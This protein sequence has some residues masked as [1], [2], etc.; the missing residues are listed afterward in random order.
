V[1]VTASDAVSGLGTTFYQL[2]GAA[3][4]TCTG[5]VN[6]SAEGANTL[7]YWSVDAAGNAEAM[8]T[9][10]VRI[11][12]TFPSTA[13]NADTAWHKATFP[14]T[15]TASDTP[16]GLAASYYTV[17][18]GA[19]TTYTGPVSISA[20]GTNTVVFWSVDRAGN[21][22]SRGSAQVLIDLTAPVTSS[23]ATSSYTSTATIHLTASD[24]LSGVASTSWRADGGAWSSEP[25]AVVSTPG[26]HVIEYYSS[27]VA[28]NAET[29]Q[30]RTFTIWKRYEQTEPTLYYEGKW[31]DASNPAYS[32]GSYRYMTAAGAANVTFSGTQMTWVTSK[33]TSFGIAR[34]SVDGGA[35]TQVD[36]YSATTQHRQAVWSTG[37]LAD[38]PHT[39][40]IEWTGQRNASATNNYVGV[41]ALDIAGVPTPKRYEQTD[42]LQYYDGTWYDASNAS[43]SG[44]SYKYTNSGYTMVSFT[45]TRVD[46]ITTKGTVFGIAQ[47]SVDGGAP[48]EVDLY[49]PS[50]VHKQKV[51]S[52]EGLANTPHTVRIDWTGAKNASASAANVGVDAF[53]IVGQPMG[54]RYE[55]S[56]PSIYLEGT[57]LEGTSSNYSGGTYR[58]TNGGNAAVTFAGTSIDWVTTKGPVFGI[59]RVSIDGG[60]GTDVDLYAATTA[61][62]QKVWSATGLTPGQHTLRIEWTG[63]KNTAATAANVGIDAVDIVGRPTLAHYEQTATDLRFE[64]S[65]LTGTSS[66]YSGA[67]Y[68]Y[69]FSAGSAVNIAFRGTRIDWITSKGPSF[70]IAR[71]AVDNGAPVLVDLYAASTANKR[72]VWSATGLASGLHHVRIEWTGTKN[73]AAT[74]TNVGIDAL[75]ILGVLAPAED[76]PMVTRFDEASPQLG[77]TGGWRTSSSSSFSGG[78]YRYTAEEGTLTVSFTGTRID[79]IG[80]KTPRSGIASVS[81]DGGAPVQVDLY[82]ASNVHQQ[83]LWSATGLSEGDHTVTI[84]WTGQHAASASDAYISVDALDIVG[85]LRQVQ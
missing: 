39:V 10:T 67:S 76:G 62:K 6:V 45:G 13:S 33:G 56:D 21:A 49:A 78:T 31:L 85:T 74:G 57:W 9:A 1:S 17:N 38:G 50:T 25:V 8:K 75:D 47:V 81:V 15:L 52:A 68:K 20:E 69:T 61:Y 43:Y 14:L 40:R 60:A 18:G 77:W 28:G 66:S 48:V 4:T 79:W 80:T 29:H 36:L 65:W 27:D 58:Y 59:A 26:Q 83:R 71:V 5:P 2:N 3:V 51:W 70:G 32:G 7:A 46:W 12:R 73:A 35:P 82:A 42:P 84:S 22:E 34:V 24:P 64:G 54:A 23:D 16:A 55:Q 41:D 44:G 30:T 72:V 37:A 63:T 19:D 11:D 53:D